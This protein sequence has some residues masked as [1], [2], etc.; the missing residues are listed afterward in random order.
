MTERL[1][2]CILVEAHS[3]AEAS[4][5]GSN[6]RI[7]DYVHGLSPNPGRYSTARVLARNRK[8]HG[9]HTA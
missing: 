9:F 6:E 2:R 7:P 8:D 1:V 4:H 5:H 3:D